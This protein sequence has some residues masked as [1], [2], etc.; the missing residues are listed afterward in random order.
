MTPAT[1]RAI[2]SLEYIADQLA[3]TARDDLAQ[4]A[5]RSARM[6]ADEYLSAQ[7]SD[8]E[9]ALERIR[10]IVGVR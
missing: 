8:A 6:L 7:P 3:D 4:I 9:Q 10:K 2:E 1:R 5:K